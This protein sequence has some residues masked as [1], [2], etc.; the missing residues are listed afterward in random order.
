MADD[1]NN[2]GVEMFNHVDQFMA[3]VSAMAGNGHVKQRL[4]QAYDENL[5]SIDEAE[6]PAPARKRFAELR[7][8]ME[9]VAPLNGEGPIRATVRKMS[10]HDTERAARLMVEVMAEVI[11]HADARQARLPLQAEERPSVPRFLSKSH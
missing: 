4:I 8:L 3:A 2:A 6:L 10:V 5:R 11:R 1:K 9:S 7:R